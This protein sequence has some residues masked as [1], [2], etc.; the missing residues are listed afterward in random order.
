M[1]R[2]PVTMIVGTDIGVGKTWT[3]LA[4]ARAL[5][6]SAHRVVAIKPLETGCSGPPGEQEDG[7][8]LARATGQS[9]PRHALLRFCD[10]VAPPEAADREGRHIDFEALVRTIR[11][12][13]ARADVCLVEAAGGLLSP[14]TWERSAVDLAQAL[15]ARVLLV[16]ADRL[17]TINHTLLALKVLEMS[18]LV[19]AG[20]VLTPPAQPDASSGSN[21]MAISRVSG[22]S[23]VVCAPRVRDPDH[24]WEKV[25]E[26]IQWL[27][28]A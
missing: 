7:V 9:E 4:L 14:L 5:C 22:C 12:H 17:G 11:E 28:L 13:T 23:R 20:V 6:R 27:E 18:R 3:G 15:D 19:V 21:A 1:L 25:K 2:V 24:A 26:T 10:P 16:A 8:A